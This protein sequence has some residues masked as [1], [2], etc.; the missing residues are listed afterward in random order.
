VRT[1]TV[2]KPGDLR[3]ERSASRM[4]E[5]GNGREAPAPH[6]SRVDHC[7]DR[8]N[9]PL[10]H[11]ELPLQ[12]VGNLVSLEERQRPSKPSRNRHRLVPVS[13]REFEPT[14]AYPEAADF[15]WPPLS[16]RWTLRRDAAPSG[17]GFQPKFV[18]AKPTHHLPSGLRLT[19]PRPPDSGND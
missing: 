10:A 15:R 17:F 6:P 16:E 18:G 2:V 12:P 7:S 9:A 8:A 13:G 19:R 1:A 5:M 11:L 3:R 4:W 14:T